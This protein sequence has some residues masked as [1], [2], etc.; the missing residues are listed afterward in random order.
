MSTHPGID[1]GRIMQV[2][3]GFFATKT[4]LSAVELGL[5]TSLAKEPKPASTI[6]RELGLHP[7][8]TADFLDALVAL[9]FLHREGK[10][11]EGTYKNAADVDLF[12]DKNKP[13][14]MGGIL[15]LCNQRLYGLWGNL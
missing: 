10:S 15:E 2:G 4:L 7:R 8:A 12:L 14:Y 3:T 6:E 13:T 5:F 9:G 11:L 1:P